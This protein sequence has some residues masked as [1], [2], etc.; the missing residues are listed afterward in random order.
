LPTPSLLTSG[1]IDDEI[2][3][4]F[5]RDGAVAVR[6]LLDDEWVELL[7]GHVEEMRERGYDPRSRVGA[8]ADEEPAVLTSDSI[9]LTS[10]EFRRFLFESPIA[11]AAAALMRSRTARLYED[12]LLYSKPNAPARTGWHQDEPAWPVGGRQM[13][14]VWLSLEEVTPSTG[15]MRFVPGSH[16]G[17][18]YWPKAGPEAMEKMAPDRVFWDGGPFPDVDG[19]TDRFPVIT[20]PAEPGD[21]V[22][23]HPR[24]LHTAYG[25]S[26][27]RPR[28]TFTVRMMGDD[29]RWLPKRSLYYRWM[30][31]NG[32]NQGDVLDHPRFPEL[33]PST[34]MPLEVPEPV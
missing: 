19:E 17:P 7:R 18:M 12:L 3:D 21:V 25:S 26:D 6:G 1:V 34:T 15:A 10:L 2:I 32:L 9:W 23:F 5:Q 8:T 33:W 29:V 31:D 4:T 16:V 28:R 14:S 20:I 13:S 24:I 27:S 11:E 30:R 22:V